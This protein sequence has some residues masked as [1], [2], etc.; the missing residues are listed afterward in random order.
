M[1]L[2]LDRDRTGA[3]KTDNVNNSKA[4]GQTRFTTRVKHSL[5]KGYTE[6]IIQNEVSIR[7][8]DYECGK[9]HSIFSQSKLTFEQWSYIHFGFDFFG[10][11][12]RPTIQLRDSPLELSIVSR[13][14]IPK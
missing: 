5:K 12:T 2:W 7:Q 4:R 14:D 10:Y 9:C 13:G 3:Y 8:E 6:M 1:W 11:D